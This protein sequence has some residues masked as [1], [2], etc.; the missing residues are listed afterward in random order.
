MRRIFFI[1]FLMFSAF[2]LSGCNPLEWKQQAGLQV[3]TQEVSAALFLDDQ[4]LDKTPYINKK[5][6]PGNYTLRIQPDDSS[7][8]S[9]DIPITLNKG[10]ITVVDWQ[11]GTSLETS[12]GIIYE[13]E[14]TRTGK[15]SQIDFQTIPNNAILT[16]DDGIK[17]FSP[18]T[19]TD[20]AEGNHTFEVSLPSYRAQ[21]HAVNIIKNHSITLTIILGKE[22]DQ[23]ADQQLTD[24]ET[25]L[26]PD[27][28]SSAGTNSETL[29][30]SLSS[31]SSTSTAKVQILSTDFFVNDKEVLRVREEPSAAGKELGFAEV[32]KKYPYKEE[33]TGWFGIEFE[34]KIGWISSQFSQKIAT[35]SAELQ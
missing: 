31:N 12:G 6:K 16:F 19:L 20:I 5:I 23:K 15:G 22:L 27:A 3:I 7:L 24:Q 13:M 9:Y 2:F 33:I 4:Y 30:N 35:P 32:G 8:V 29:E 26:A 17:Q 1:S 14:K 34:N 10:T 28:S 25:I 18:L 11:S 21:Q